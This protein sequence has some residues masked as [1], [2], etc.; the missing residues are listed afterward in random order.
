VAFKRFI[1]PRLGLAA[2]LGATGRSPAGLLE[3]LGRYPVGS[4]STL[5]LL[6]LDRRVLLLSQQRSGRVGLR[7]G[8]AGFTPLCE[9]TDPDEVAS[10]LAKARDAEGESI[11]ARFRTLLTSFEAA[12]GDQQAPARTTDAPQPPS[13]TP[14]LP[15]SGAAESLPHPPRGHAHRRG[16]A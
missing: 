2:S 10:I 3:I 6:K 9:V 13:M 14:A 12:P 4:G 5:V 15:R 11:S 8:A 7:S 16:Q 1:A